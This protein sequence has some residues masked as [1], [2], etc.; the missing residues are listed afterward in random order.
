MSGMRSKWTNV[1]SGDIRGRSD[2]SSDSEYT[3]E[4][5]VE[6]LIGT[7]VV[8]EAGGELAIDLV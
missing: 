8:G 5:G 4:R 2:S 3:A 1:L 7:L 6:L